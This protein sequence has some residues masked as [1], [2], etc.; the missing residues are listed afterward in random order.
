MQIKLCSNHQAKN[1]LR[2]SVT[3]GTTPTAES[4]RSRPEVR[5]QI[6]AG[7]GGFPEPRV[8]TICPED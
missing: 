2:F 5:P 3:E 1:R 4:G 8:T 7:G 6:G